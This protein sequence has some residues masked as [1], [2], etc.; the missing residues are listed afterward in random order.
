MALFP[1]G[2][3]SCGFG[4]GFCK[5]QSPFQGCAV[6]TALT[7]AQGTDDRTWTVF[8][9]RLAD[10]EEA[11]GA[12]DREQPLLGCAIADEIGVGQPVGGGQIGVE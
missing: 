11:L 9:S 10:A 3:T 7:K 8:I 12:H 4:L 2:G 1:P 6:L 5:H